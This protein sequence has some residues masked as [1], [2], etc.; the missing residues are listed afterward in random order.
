MGS[1]NFIDLPVGLVLTQHQV[2]R[3]LVL[4]STL[5]IT[6]ENFRDEIILLKMEAGSI[7]G[8][9]QKTNQP[10]TELKG[11]TTCPIN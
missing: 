2:T 5:N 7:L 1:S 8:N 4:A 9:I 3:L 6:N 10:P 11:D